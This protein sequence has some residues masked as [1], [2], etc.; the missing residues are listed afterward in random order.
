MTKGGSR[1][2]LA[3]CAVLAVAAVGVAA[4]L[5]RDSRISAPSL[6]PDFPA[7]DRAALSP[8]QQRIVDLLQAQYDAQPAGTTYSEG[9]D[10]PWCADFVSWVLN[11]AGRPLSNPH[12]GHWRIPGVYTL[13][14][15]Y[16]AAGRFEAPD[17]YR[18]QT[19]DVALY[20]DGSPLGLHTNFVLAV[21]D[22]GITTVG[23]NEEGDIKV[24][25]IDPGPWL[26][27]YGRLA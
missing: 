17:G 8:V 6:R 19:G 27:G 9:V 22:N 13:Q 23:G 16:Q 18:P 24:R 20:A 2:W 7:L 12:S 4:V 25:T 10:E 21:D 5:F 26:L 1:L 14:E 11:E 15:Y 3:L